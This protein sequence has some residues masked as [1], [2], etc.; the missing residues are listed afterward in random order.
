MFQ[1]SY[2]HLPH[3][4]VLGNHKPHS[5]GGDILTTLDPTKTIYDVYCIFFT[6][7]YMIIFEVS[8]RKLYIQDRDLKRKSLDVSEKKLEEIQECHLVTLIVSYWWT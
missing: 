3:N 4:W 7:W 6:K 1:K 2:S 8:N 5:D